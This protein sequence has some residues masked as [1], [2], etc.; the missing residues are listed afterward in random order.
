MSWFDDD[1]Q[2]DYRS[3]NKIGKPM[4]HGHPH[5][6]NKAERKK[7]AELMQASGDSEEVVRSNYFNRKA[8]SAAAKTPAARGTT[9][10]QR[11]AIK[12]RA[13]S[14]MK[15]KGMQPWEAIAQA[16]KDFKAGKTS[17]WA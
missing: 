7:L 4:G 1:I 3:T 17:R 6:P 8:L 14:M 5:I 9:D 16:E 15:Y 2:V 11:L 10:R 13:R 12:R